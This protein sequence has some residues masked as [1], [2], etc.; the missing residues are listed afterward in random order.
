MGI[1]YKAVNAVTGEIYVGATTCSLNKR[2]DEHVRSSKTT[3]KDLKFHK[4]IRE[5]GEANFDIE[6][7]EEVPNHMLAEREKYYIRHFDSYHNGYNSTLGGPGSNQIEY[8]KIYDLWEAGYNCREIARELD[9]CPQTVITAM[10]AYDGY[11][12]SE[13]IHRGKRNQM[14]KVRQYDMDGNYIREF[15]S[16]ADAARAYDVDRTLIS[17]VCRRKRHSGAGYQWRY[18]DDE[19]PLDYV[20]EQK[21]MRRIE[22]YSLDGEYIDIFDSITD[23][24]NTFGISHSSISA[25]CSGKNKTAGGYRWRYAE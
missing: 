2:W 5:Y 3:E 4:A 14:H 6:V 12:A 1:I 22:Q 19:P 17:A 15:E 21:N 25:C 13:S 9:I 10:N 8:E 18:A 24:S 7:I 16:T 20:S 23:A 11:T